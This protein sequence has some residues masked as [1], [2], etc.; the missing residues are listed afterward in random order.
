MIMEPKRLWKIYDCENFYLR[1]LNRSKG[2]LKI[3]TG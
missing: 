1:I 3:S 2:G